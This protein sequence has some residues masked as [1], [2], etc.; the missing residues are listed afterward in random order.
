LIVLGLVR[1]PI[2]EALAFCALYGARRT[3]SIGYAK[4][5]A[6]AVAKIELDQIAVQMSL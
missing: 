5:G 6:N 1:P 3:F 4:F 2:R